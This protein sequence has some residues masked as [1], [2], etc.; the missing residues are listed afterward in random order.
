MSIKKVLIAN[1]GEIACRIIRTCREKG[2]KTVAVYSEADQEMPFVKM[3]DEAVCIGPPPVPKSYLNMEAL[4]DAAFETKADAIHPGY[5]F[6][7]ENAVFAEKVQANG[8]IWIGSDPS[9]ISRMGDKVVA[10]QTMKKA[11]IPVIPGS[12]G[13]SR[14]EDAVA[15]A[16][17]MGYP[18]L[19]KA[20]AGGGGIGMQVCLNEDELKKHF[21]PLKNRAKA[22]FGHDGLF[23]EK[24]ISPARHVEVQIA[25]DQH[26]NVVHLFERECSVQ[27]RNQ[28]VIEEGLSPSIYEST[29]EKLR[30]A[31]VEAAKAAQFTGVGTVEFLVDATEQFYF[32]EMN[33]RLQVEHPVT[34]A[35]TGVDLVDWQICLAEG[36]PLPLKQEEIS[37]RGHAMEFRIYAEDPER[38]LPSP[39]KVTRLSFPEGEG[40]RVDTGI[41]EGNVVSPFYDPMI[42]KLIVSGC[43][44]AEVWK[45]AGEAL[46]KCKVEGIKTNLPLLKSVLESEPFQQGSYDTKLIQNILK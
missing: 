1:R 9:V 10:R 7:S 39:G 12:D 23:I 28:K 25:A 2:L 45:K 37:G 13:L 32:L 18:V 6:L 34:E 46:Q 20:S 42:A 31:A 19:V 44:R 16:G 41:Q 15:V 11:G 8:L 14:P 36:K 35:I 21:Q 24:V 26:G 4:L 33:T 5:G 27:R 43:N 30:K 29:R 38:F 3:A 17:E 40:V 22:Y